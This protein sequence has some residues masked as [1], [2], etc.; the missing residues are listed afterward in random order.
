[1]KFIL[2]LFCSLALF[3]NDVTKMVTW[4]CKTNRFHRLFQCF[5]VPRVQLCDCKRSAWEQQTGHMRR[6]CSSP[7]DSAAITHSL[8]RWLV[9]TLRSSREGSLSAADLKRQ[10]KTPLWEMKQ[11]FLFWL[12]TTWSWAG[13]KHQSDARAGKLQNLLLESP[14]VH[15]ESWD[16]KSSL[17]IDYSALQHLKY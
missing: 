7:S 16:V 6:Q 2:F 11:C 13:C 15:R 12:Q 1:M 17:R 5:A 3:W 9:F 14:F 8:Q 10:N 4:I